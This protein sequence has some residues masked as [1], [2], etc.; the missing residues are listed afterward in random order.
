MCD[1]DI[2]T[3]FLNVFRQFQDNVVNNSAIPTFPLIDLTSA[4]KQLIASEQRMAGMAVAASGIV[5][6]DVAKHLSAAVR[7][8]FS[9]L[10]NDYWITILHTYIRIN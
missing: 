9:M 10:G 2:I 1:I 5:F 6:G 7:L 8:R 3:P 4:V